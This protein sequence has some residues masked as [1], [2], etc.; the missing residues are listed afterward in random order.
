MSAVPTALASRLIKLIAVLR[1]GKANVGV[2]A[3]DRE[4]QDLAIGRTYSLASLQHL[5]GP[6]C[7]PDSVVKESLLHYAA[8]DLGQ[9]GCAVMAVLDLGLWHTSQIRKLLPQLEPPRDTEMVIQALLRHAKDRGETVVDLKLLDIWAGRGQCAAVAAALAN[10][11]CIGLLRLADLP[12]LRSMDKWCDECTTRIFEVLRY[13][14]CHG[15]ICLIREALKS[16]LSTWRPSLLS[17]QFWRLMEVVFAE[18]GQLDRHCVRLAKPTLV[19]F[20]AKHPQTLPRCA[21]YMLCDRHGGTISVLVPR[22]LLVLI[23]AHRKMPFNDAVSALGVDNIRTLLR[24]D[25]P[26]FEFDSATIANHVRRI[27]ELIPH[28][29]EELL[30]KPAFAKR[31]IRKSPDINETFTQ[32]WFKDNNI[33]AKSGTIF[34]WLLQHRRAAYR[35]PAAI[36]RRDLC[37]SDFAA[38]LC[39]GR[40][41]NPDS[42]LALLDDW[43]MRT[44]I[45]RFVKPHK[46]RRV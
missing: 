23:A 39:A 38:R 27:P 32:L 14:G 41:V 22:E 20:V 9:C 34:W 31:L 11:S 19:E 8:I 37:T 43:L 16:D 45:S 18:K 30:L 29:P 6:Q 42:P 25:L 10:Q 35:S 13:Q 26:F 5:M 12:G 44:L 3:N 15:N 40:L 2:S 7:I 33:A 1:E 17:A 36:Y 46:A 24:M 28:L 21:L 4:L